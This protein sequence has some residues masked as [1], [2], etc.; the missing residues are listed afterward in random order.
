MAVQG[1]ADDSPQI[2]AAHWA[3]HPALLSQD[4]MSREGSCNDC[5]NCSLT[6]LVCGGYNVQSCF[7]HCGARPIQRSKDNLRCKHNIGMLFLCIKYMHQSWPAIMCRH[8]VVVLVSWS[9]RRQLQNLAHLPF[10]CRVFMTKTGQVYTW[11]SAHCRTLKTG[12][13]TS[14]PFE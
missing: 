5:H 3:C 1:L 2:I 6:F 7:P 4:C 8:S 12:D 11:W 14:S 9:N 13:P 10:N